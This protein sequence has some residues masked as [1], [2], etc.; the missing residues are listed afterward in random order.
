MWTVIG[1]DGQEYGPVNDSTL[2]E[3]V[4]QGRVTPE[5]RLLDGNRSMVSAGSLPGLFGPAAPANMAYYPRG[6]QTAPKSKLAAI[7]FAVFLGSLGIHRFYL[8]HTATGILMLLGS[9]IGI[10][11]TF[12]ISAVIVAVWGFVDA[13][14]IATDALGDKNGVP[15]V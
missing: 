4:A 3:W 5:T 12:G 9:T 11:L 6:L 8:G 1:V 2:R 14:L 10:C 7:L 15:L 13:F